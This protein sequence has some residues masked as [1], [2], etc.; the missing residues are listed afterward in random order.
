MHM[1]WWEGGRGREG[2]IEEHDKVS[3]QG[4]TS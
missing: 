2:V 4:N 3:V 1:G